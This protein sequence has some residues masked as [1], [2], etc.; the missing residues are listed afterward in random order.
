MKWTC[1][2][3]RTFVSNWPLNEETSRFIKNRLC[4]PPIKDMK[5]KK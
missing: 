1:N 3:L 2:S 4:A 5:S